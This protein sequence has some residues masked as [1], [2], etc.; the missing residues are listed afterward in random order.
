MAKTK[1]P[2]KKMAAVRLAVKELGVEAPVA[3]V[4]KWV[5]ERYN[6]DLT[7]ATA[8]TYVSGAK[9]ELREANGN[10]ARLQGR[11][12]AAPAPSPARATPKATGN[13]VAIDQVVGAL[14]TLKELVGTLGKD[15]LLKLVEAL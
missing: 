2:I 12:K 10:P 1:P 14:T 6:I 15:N 9:R 11:P 4:R 13:G 7:D 5:K 3:Q 8:Q